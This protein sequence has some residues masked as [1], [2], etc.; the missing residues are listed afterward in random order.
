M[1]IGYFEVHTL[2]MNSY[3]F[4]DLYMLLQSRNWNFEKNQNKMGDVRR[5]NL[6]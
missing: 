2:D 1:Q 5:D 4:K 6:S 3:F